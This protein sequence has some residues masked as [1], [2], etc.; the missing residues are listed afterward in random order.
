MKEGFTLMDLLESQPRDFGF[1]G[2]QPGRLLSGEP[3]SPEVA[4]AVPIA[5]GRVLEQARRWRGCVVPA[6]IR[7]LL[8]R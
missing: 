6:S 5:A 8:A 7:P 1:P 4:S 2:R 3:S